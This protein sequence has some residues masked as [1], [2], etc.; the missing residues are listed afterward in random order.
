M[1]TVDRYIPA[2]C[3]QLSNYVRLY[4]QLRANQD[5]FAIARTASF[6]VRVVCRAW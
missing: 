4:A 1:C 3:T 6:H 2:Q 5:A